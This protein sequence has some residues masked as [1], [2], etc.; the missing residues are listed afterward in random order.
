MRN[1]FMA[2]VITFTLTSCLSPSINLDAQDPNM[3]VVS[4]ISIGAG[5]DRNMEREFKSFLRTKY[6]QLSYE[7]SPAG[8]EG[9][10][11]Y[12]FD[13]SDLSEEQQAIFR[14]ES[15]KLLEKSRLVEISEPENCPN[16]LR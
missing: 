13:L 1:Y 5:I 14:E 7:V 12:C 3:F 6:P 16:K 8:Y 15:L 9:E 10:G 2:I 11:N 4:F